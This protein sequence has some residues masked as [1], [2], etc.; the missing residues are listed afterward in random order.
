MRCG[1]YKMQGP[2]PITVIVREANNIKV[3]VSK[4]PQR[5]SCWGLANE[6]R[7]VIYKIHGPE[8][9]AVFALEANNVVV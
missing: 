8:L 1:I 7:F 6:G 2:E 4:Q 9:L 5:D 3:Y